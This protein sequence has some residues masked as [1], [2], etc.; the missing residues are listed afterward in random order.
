MSPPMAAAGG[1][2]LPAESPGVQRPDGPFVRRAWGLIHPYFASEARWQAI[3][4]L[5]A[6]VAL[7]LVT[8]YVDVLLNGFQ[9][10]FFNALESKDYAEFRRQLWHFAG[11]ATAFIL[12]AVYKFYL[13]QIFELRW[14]TWLTTRYVDGWLSQRAYYRL[15]LGGAQTD[16]P[17]QRI[18]EDIRLFT[19]YTVSLTM[20]LLNSVVTLA[21][22]ITILWVVS[23]PL[24]LTIGDTPVT[25][26][27]YM[28][29]V[30]LLYAVAGSWLSHVIGRPLIALNF[31]QQRF[32]A[33]FRY[34]LVRIREYA[35]SIALY[36]GE[37][38]ERTGLLDRFGQVVTN[39]LA[40]I[41]AQ[42]KL[43]WAQSFYGQ[44]AVIF[45]FIVAAPR[46]FNGPLKLGDVMQIANAFGQVQGSLSWFVN[47]YASLATWKATTDRLL[48][49]DD[50]IATLRGADDRLLQA[51][52]G[53]A[54]AL[55]GVRLET[56]AGLPIVAEATLSIRPAE[57]VLLTGPSGSG[58]STLFR[59]LAG[60]WPHGTG[61]IEQP[62]GGVLFLP[63]KPYLPIGTLRST[64]SYPAAPDAFDDVAIAQALR[65]CRLPQL[66]DCLDESASWDRRLS[67]G[68]QQRLA[69][70][71]ALL[72]RPRWLFMDE[73]TAALD[74]ATGTAL[75]RLL[76]ERLPDT[77]VISIAHDPSVAQF[78]QRRVHLTPAEDGA[79][80]SETGP[81]PAFVP[82]R[83]TGDA[84]SRDAPGAG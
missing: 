38:P 64:V 33:D 62:D 80:L 47:A 15:E 63:Q 57:R 82:T 19:E 20:G 73:A 70:A 44:L 34:G 29:W 75:Y 23:G 81:T 45:P 55:H 69:F 84:P 12:V 67:P 28:V 54:P 59:A 52:P 5:A 31:A 74:E 76:L 50:A 2:A 71:R 68:E 83:A 7:N 79:R 18:A 66:A 61:R 49:F 22:F 65:D 11:L 32:E 14:R 36:R 24:T 9:R 17:D 53:P 40:L 26:P 10:D 35:E 21:S 60:I 51:G 16:N 25:I 46:Y 4:L 48:T 41:R 30:A 72:N 58:K 6:V 39:Y 13:T 56:P 8:V 1:A 43:I 78:H 37:R 27:G 42:K 77:A 3:G